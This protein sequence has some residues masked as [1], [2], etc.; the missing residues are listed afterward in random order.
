MNTKQISEFCRAFPA[1]HFYLDEQTIREAIAHRTQFNIIHL[2]SGLKIDVM[3]PDDSSFNQSRFARGLRVRPAPDYEATFAA[4]EDV[5][6]KKMEYYRDGGSE[7]HLRDITGVL[8]VSGDRVDRAYIADWSSRLDLEPVWHAV[9][10]R[11]VD[12]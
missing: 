9:L 11:L 12:G 4:I 8:R 2:S 3:I 10:Q 7:K 6:I 5:I 1:A